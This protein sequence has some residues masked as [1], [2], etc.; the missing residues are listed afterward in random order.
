MV[1]ML[2]AFLLAV[3]SI[4]CILMP[5]QVWKAFNVGDDTNEYGLNDINLVALSTSFPSPLSHLLHPIPS[6][7]PL[8]RSPPF[9]TALN[10]CGFV[11]TAVDLLHIL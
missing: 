8:P 3:L 9:C 5:D 11:I 10:R 7:I 6:Q 4:P 2:L 1:V